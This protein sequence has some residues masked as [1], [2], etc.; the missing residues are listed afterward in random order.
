MR[1]L[2]DVKK[3]EEEELEQDGCNKVNISNAYVEFK[4]QFL[5]T[6]FGFESVQEGH[7]GQFNIAKHHVKLS[8]ADASPIYSVAYQ[9]SLKVR[10]FENK[11]TTNFRWKNSSSWL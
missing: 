7:L 5:E 9:T 8:P 10:E 4:E 11:R 6:Q 3:I 2:E 1:N